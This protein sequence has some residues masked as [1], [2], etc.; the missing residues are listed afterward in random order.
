MRRWL[1][2]LSRGVEP[3]WNELAAAVELGK[4]AWRYLE[5]LEKPSRCTLRYCCSAAQARLARVGTGAS[6][7]EGNCLF[8]GLRFG[9]EGGE[10]ALDNRGDVGET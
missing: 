4:M 8:R 5:C 3:E 9:V 2:R 1:R 6:S 10:E 7:S